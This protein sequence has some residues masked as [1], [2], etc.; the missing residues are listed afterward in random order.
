MIILCFISSFYDEDCQG[1]LDTQLVSKSNVCNYFPPFYMQQNLNFSSGQNYFSVYN[2]S[3]GDCSDP[4]ALVSNSSFTVDIGVC[5]SGVL[6]TVAVYE[7]DSDKFYSPQYMTRLQYEKSDTSC[8]DDAHLAEVTFYG[9]CRTSEGG[10]SSLQMLSFGR[11]IYKGK[12]NV[13]QFFIF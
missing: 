6:S 10:T 8:S 2:A 12:Y 3:I 4:S 7:E 1:S 11:E 5:N 9:Y 13:I